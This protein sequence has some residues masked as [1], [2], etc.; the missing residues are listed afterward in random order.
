MN[1]KFLSSAII[2][3]ALVL[4]ACSSLTIVSSSGQQPAPVEESGP[5]TGYQP[6]ALDQVLAEVG[7]GSPIPIHAVV[8]LNLPS[9]FAQL[10]EIR[11]HRAGTT[12]YVRLIADVVQREDCISDSIPFRLEVPLNIVNL[13]EGP[14]EV[15]VN[16]TTASFDPRT[17]TDEGHGLAACTEYVA[18][19]VVNDSVSYNG[20]SFTIDPALD[21]SVTAQRCP[22]VLPTMDQGPG[23]AHPPYIAFSTPC[24]YPS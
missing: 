7:G 13:P 15:N 3:L 12:F 10:G 2:T 18:A 22:A 1:T 20:I 5:V 23:E 21:H 4:S 6:V 14:Y 16:G 9:T 17:D 24:V 8:G 11:L 19:P